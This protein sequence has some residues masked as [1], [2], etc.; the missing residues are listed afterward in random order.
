M[1]RGTDGQRLS[2]DV[3]GQEIKISSD[4]P[5]PHQPRLQPGATDLAAWAVGQEGNREMLIAM[6]MEGRTNVRMEPRFRSPRRPVNAHRSLS[7]HKFSWASELYWMN[8]LEMVDLSLDPN[9][10]GNLPRDEY[11]ELAFQS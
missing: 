5:K 10:L 6:A 4:F 1:R 8:P 11:P 9:I 3:Q 2:S 7:L